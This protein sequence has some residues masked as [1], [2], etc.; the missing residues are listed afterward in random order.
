MDLYM[1]GSTVGVNFGHTY[2]PGAPGRLATSYDRSYHT[3]YEEEEVLWEEGEELTFTIKE[4]EVFEVIQKSSR[5]MSGITK[6]K[7]SQNKTSS[8]KLVSRF[9]EDINEAI[10]VKQES[11]QRAKSEILHQE[12]CFKDEAIFIKTF[13][14]G[15]AKDVVMLNVSGTIMVTKR[16]TL[17]FFAE[18]VLA[19]QF[20]DAI[21]TNQGNATTH[22][23]KVKEWTSDDVSNWADNIEGIQ[24]DV[25]SILKENGINAR[26]LLA[27]NMEGLKMIG[28]ER[29]GTLCLLLEEIKMLKQASSDNMTLIEHSPYCFGK[30]VDYLRLKQLHSQGLVEEPDRPTVCDSQK[31]RFEK[32]VRYYFPGDSAKFILG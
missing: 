21:W 15:D 11:L 6:E 25:G 12:D 29:A 8:L 27:L 17:S 30:I 19:R 28:I 2:E 5:T 9:S 26:E 14:S 31:G 20:D 24:D 1:S 7:K 22:C 32:V 13:A 16:S 3:E 23:V 10:N 4:I 18:S